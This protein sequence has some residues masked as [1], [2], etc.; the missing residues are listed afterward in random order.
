MGTC[1]LG[2]CAPG[3][4]HLSAGFITIL[5]SPPLWSHSTAVPTVLAGVSEAPESK[6]GTYGQRTRALSAPPFHSQSSTF[7]LPLSGLPLHQER[8]PPKLLSR[9]AENIL[10]PGRKR[11]G[12]EQS[13]RSKATQGRKTTIRGSSGQSQ[14]SPWAPKAGWAQTC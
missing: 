3:I 12:R 2:R 13:G 6:L 1:A 4:L 5:L 9:Q 8:L 14:T 11:I 10:I 7:M